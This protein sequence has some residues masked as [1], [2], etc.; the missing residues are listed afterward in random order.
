MTNTK[1]SQS[2][3]KLNLASTQ[4]E[5]DEQVIVLSAAKKT[6]PE[7]QSVSPLS[8]GE[9]EQKT[10]FATS[11]LG[12]DFFDQLTP[13]PADFLSSDDEDGPILVLKAEKKSSEEEEPLILLDEKKKITSSTTKKDSFQLDPPQNSA[14]IV[15]PFAASPQKVDEEDVP[16]AI[17][18]PTGTDPSLKSISI[19]QDEPKEEKEHSG[20]TSENASPKTEKLSPPLEE[21]VP[22]SITKEEVH[23]AKE[24]AVAAL[25]PDATR[26]DESLSEEFLLHG[27]L[28]ELTRHASRA[29]CFILKGSLVIGY[30]AAGEE[31]IDL[32]VKEI[33]FPINAP[34]IF[35]QVFQTRTPYYGTLPA[36]A[37]DQIV[38]A[39]LGESSPHKV[40]LFPVI[41]DER[42]VAFFYL[43]DAGP[44]PLTDDIESIQQMMMRASLLEYR[45]QPPK[46]EDLM[47][48]F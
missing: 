45:W 42:I 25:T 48:N 1:D 23:P 37:M 36:T 41:R 39:C 21:E 19:P 17:A 2:P 10:D 4:E 32:R 44:T 34:S 8:S 13:S 38:I 28:S 20:G 35:F 18:P 16:W 7:V 31:E 3:S 40:A 30:E 5:E 29:C 24:I 9:K 11:I 26:E 15:P 43:D 33:L 46:L 22:F 27:F 12:D 47:Q 6:I 14:S